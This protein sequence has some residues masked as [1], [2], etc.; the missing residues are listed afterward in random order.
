MLLA[1]DIYVAY[2]PVSVYIIYISFHILNLLIESGPFSP[3][4][5]YAVQALASS[6]ITMRSRISHIFSQVYEHSPQ[7]SYL[8]S[9]SE[10]PV[11]I[12]RHI[13]WIKTNGDGEDHHEF[14]STMKP[15]FQI[16]VIKRNL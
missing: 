5:L 11:N 7:T 8:Q 10:S 9:V 12:L 13:A 14:C 2:M 16:H 15:H 4:F 3:I 6:R 1:L